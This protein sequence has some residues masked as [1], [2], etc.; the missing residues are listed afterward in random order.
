MPENLPLY[1]SDGLLTWYDK[2]KRK[3]F[4]EDRDAHF[5]KKK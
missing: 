5:K 1:E 2:E 3:E 4:L